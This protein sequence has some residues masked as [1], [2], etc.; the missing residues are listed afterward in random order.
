[1]AS[2]RYGGY[3]ARKQTHLHKLAIV[4]SAAQRDELLIQREDLEHANAFLED[5]ERSMIKVFES[6]GIVDEAK[7][8]AEL[9]TYVRSLSWITG[10]ELYKLCYNIMSEKDFKQALRIAC[11]GELLEVI[12]RNGIRGVSPKARK[13]SS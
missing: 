10:P 4:L 11:E 12:V 8:V 7:H 2:G 5:S 3:L 6:V 9:V 1:M 13:M